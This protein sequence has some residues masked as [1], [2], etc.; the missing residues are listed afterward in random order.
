[1]AL[2]RSE[3]AKTS[4]RA[5]LAVCSPGKI[6]SHEGVENEL[7][8]TSPPV[9]LVPRHRHLETAL[10]RPTLLLR[11]FRSNPARR[12]F[13]SLVRAVIIYA[14]C[15]SKYGKARFALFF[16]CR[17]RRFCLFETSRVCLRPFCGGKSNTFP[18]FFVFKSVEKLYL[19]GLSTQAPFYHKHAITK[20]DNKG[21]ILV[22]VKSA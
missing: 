20:L 9:S 14:G 4:K 5:V 3:S 1:M 18:F 7:F 21:I 15:F 19:L 11:W 10:L 16:S 17:E 22:L 13:C 12:E 2:T 8:R 6:F